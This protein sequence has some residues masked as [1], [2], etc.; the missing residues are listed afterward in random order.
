LLCRPEQDFLFARPNY[1]YFAVTQVR[2]VEEGFLCTVVL[3][4]PV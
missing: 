2:H 4:R 3:A 1:E